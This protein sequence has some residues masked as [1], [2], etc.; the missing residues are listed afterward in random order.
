MPRELSI[1][2][3]INSVDLVIPSPVARRQSR[4]PF[5]QTMQR[6]KNV[7]AKIS[8]D[9]GCQSFIHS[10]SALKIQRR[11]FLREVTRTLF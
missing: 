8:S 7:K 2:I 9:M 5:G 11:L 4:G 1:G 3:L 10:C 6:Y